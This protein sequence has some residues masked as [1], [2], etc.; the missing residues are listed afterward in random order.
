MLSG[1]KVLD[2]TQYLPGPY[3]TLRL[4]DLG[5]EVIKIERPEGDPA[6]ELSDG[7]VFQGNNRN[8]KSMAFDLKNTTDQQKVIELI[9][10]ADVLVES[11]RPGVMASL[12]LG[13]EQLRSLHPSLVYCSLTGYGQTGK[14]SMLGSH[15]LNYMALSGML[16]QMKDGSGRPVHP[17]LTFADLIGGITASEAI[18]AALLKREKNGEGSYIDLAIT[19]A[20]MS[21]L[22]THMQYAEGNG[23]PELD[24]H[25][26]SYH[27][28]ETKDRRFI[29][30]AALEP[31]FWSNFC[32]AVQKQEWLPYHVEKAEKGNRV[33]EEVCQ[34]F[35][36]R[37][38]HEW[39]IFSQQ[40]DCCMA[41]V[42]EMRE[43]KDSCYNQ[44]RQIIVE[45]PWNDLQVFTSSKPN[46]LY[47]PPGLNSN[48][49]NR[50]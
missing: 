21:L 46:Y 23:V 48:C 13:Y 22:T 34:L 36:S 14:L 16:S 37:S 18:V 32:Q 41:P 40:V 5:A 3:A 10:S 7:K 39:E 47:A 33:Y 44:Y 29:S 9:R 43:L 12:G 30:L 45:S 31:K 6:R 27:I 1:I 42:Y 17:T 50:K 38:F 26:I 25:I 4:S 15:D 24:G 11:F 8:K 35:Q 28:Y 19:D 2:F 49:L 20:V